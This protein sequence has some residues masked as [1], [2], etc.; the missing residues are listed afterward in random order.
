MYTMNKLDKILIFLL[1]NLCC[2]F[3]VNGQTL[4]DGQ[5]SVQN[6][7]VSKQEDKLFISMDL[8]ISAF[9]QRSNR[10]LFITP[11][12]TRDDKKLEL[13]AVVIAGR[14]RYYHHLRNNTTIDQLYRS[15]KHALI[16]YR[17]VIPY[18]KWMGTAML[19]AVSSTNGCCGE[20]LT[21]GSI[22]LRKLR[23]EKRIP[24][25][26]VPAYVYIRPKAGP[27]INRIE[28]SAYI[29]FPVNRTEI[30]PDYRRNPE[31]LKKILATI[32]A[33]RND[34]DTRILNISIK[35]YASPE[36]SY[37]NN[38]RL[39]KGRTVTLKEYVR[40]QYHFPDSL[41]TTAYEPEDWEGLRRFVKSS[42]LV[43]REGILH[44]IDSDLEPDEK[45]RKIKTDYRRDY[46]YLLREVYPGLRHSDYVVCYEVKD[47]TDSEEIRQLLRTQPQKLSLQEMYLVAQDMEP[48]SE[49]Y[50][51]TFEI[52]VRM[53][54]DDTTANLNAANTAMRLGNL[55]GAEKYLTKAGDTPEA[56]YARGIYAALSGSYEAAE[57]LLKEASEKGIIQAEDARR[58]IEEIK[59]VMEENRE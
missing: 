6:L 27:K 54:P 37:V 56:I 36:G 47:Y 53:F 59:K 3:G 46:D 22:P 58:Q 28:G 32:D 31:E 21:N 42:D 19:D 45:D 55:Q 52:A 5:I 50:N 10:E 15:G 44:V 34:T 25:P 18:E 2:T 17:V 9:K 8:D 33:V 41:F 4:M 49:E 48:G 11:L 7:V 35:G 16:E 1:L 29:D 30:Y 13:P 38:V 40:K 24:A 39:A 26:F 20:N 57:V 12:L 51:E 14:N 43:D 23:L